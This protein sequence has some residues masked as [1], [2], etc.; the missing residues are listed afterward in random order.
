MH[1]LRDNRQ[2][3]HSQTHL[4]W[5]V[6]GL[7]AAGA[8]PARAQEENPAEATGLRPSRAYVSVL[9]WESIDAFSGSLVLTFTDLVLPGNAGFDLRFTRAFNS[10]KLGRWTLGPGKIRWADPGGYTP[11]NPKIV[12]PD[13]GEQGTFQSAEGSSLYRTT[14]YWE[15]DRN[16]HGLRMP[17]GVTYQYDCVRSLSRY[18]TE[19]QD[20]H[21]NTV[22]F[23][24]DSCEDPNAT[25]DRCW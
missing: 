14:S 16:T 25:G 1:G 24:Y 10:K 12:T 4:I 2:V 19:A 5:M 22:T 23:T 21:G 20:A 7:L 13:G 18:P 6:I 9:P 11:H 8:L 3:R 15:Y 17:T